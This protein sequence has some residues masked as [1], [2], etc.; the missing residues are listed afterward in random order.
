MA[1]TRLNV[2]IA[3]WLRGTFNVEDEYFIEQDHLNYAKHVAFLCGADYFHAP[4]IFSVPLT[5]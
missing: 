3:H 5:P 2:R 1:A 4:V